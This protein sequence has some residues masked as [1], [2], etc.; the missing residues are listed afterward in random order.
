VAFLEK[1]TIDTNKEFITEF[2]WRLNAATSLA[3]ASVQGSRK[4]IRLSKH[5]SFLMSA[6]ICSK[7]VLHELAIRIVSL[8][9]ARP[10]KFFLLP[11][12]TGNNES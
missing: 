10:I 7:A 4:Y 9:F 3:E 2:R 1:I 5:N 11:K 8:L 12:T 6:L